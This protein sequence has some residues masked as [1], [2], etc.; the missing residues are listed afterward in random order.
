[1]TLVGGG[2][3]HSENPGCQG[4]CKNNGRIR[5]MHGRREAEKGESE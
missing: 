2:A 5:G 3:G 4:I 1:M